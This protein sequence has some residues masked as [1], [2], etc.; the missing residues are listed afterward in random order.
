MRLQIRAVGRMKPGPEQEL[1][2]LYRK[3]LSWQLDIL[4]IDDR[5]SAGSTPERIAR[6]G[7]QLQADLPPG[8]VVVAL[9]ERGRE[10]D[11][12][13]FSRTLTAWRDNARLPI[14]FMIGGADGLERELVNKADLTLCFGRM[15]WPHMMVRAMLVEQIF[16]AQSIQQGHPYHRA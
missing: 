5:K 11:S 9:D 15:T 3:R 16:R 12:R 14:V 4:E 8:A 13:E 6:E 7:A 10:L 2:D 1:L